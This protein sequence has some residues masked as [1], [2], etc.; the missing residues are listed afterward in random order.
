M[1][2]RSRIAV[3]DRGR[4]LQAAPR[5]EVFRAPHSRRVA[6]L[7][8]AR[9]VFRGTARADGGIDVDGLV[10][11]ANDAA[12][13]APGASLDVTIRAERCNLRRL[14]P[15]Q[16]PPANCFVATIVEDLPFGNAHTLRLAPAGPGPRVEIEVASRPYEVLGVAARSRWVVELPAA[17]L[18]VMKP[19]AADVA[20]DVIE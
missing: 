20:D 6:E 12:A 3:L 15:D 5:D 11:H 1:L 4:I 8:G 17:D 9:N 19:E 7:T 18:H 16:P 10:L 2:F 13:S 14:D